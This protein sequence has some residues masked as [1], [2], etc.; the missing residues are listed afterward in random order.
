MEFEIKNGVLIDYDGTDNR[1]VIPDNVSIIGSRAFDRCTTIKELVVP[2]SV[3]TIESFAFLG[4]SNLSNIELTEGLKIIKSCAFAN[5]GLSKIKLPKSV[6]KTED[7]ALNGIKD[8]TIYEKSISGYE[9]LYSICYL[10]TDPEFYSEITVLAEDDTIERCVLIDSDGKSQTEKIFSERCKMGKATFDFSKFDKNFKSIKNSK[11]KGDVAEFRINNPY[12]LSEES[13][14]MYISYLKRTS[15]N[16]IDNNNAAFEINGKTLVKYLG[17]DSQTKVVIP[18]G[19][20]TIGKHAFKE[21]NETIE[22]IVI[23]EGVTSI[24]KEG[25]R[26]AEAFWGCIKIKRFTLPD[27]LTNIP[28]GT[29]DIHKLV[30]TS[31]GLSLIRPEIEFNE[32]KSGLYLGNANNPYVCLVKVSDTS[33]S[34]ITVHDGCKVICGDVFI[35]CTELTDIFLPESIVKIEEGNTNYSYGKKDFYLKHGLKMNMPANYFKTIVKLPPTVTY[36]LL[37]NVWKDQLTFDDLVWVYLFQSGKKIEDFCIKQ[38][39][40]ESENAVKKMLAISS[41]NQTKSVVTKIVQYTFNNKDKLDK[42]TIREVLATAKKVKIQGVELKLLEDFLGENA[43]SETD[44]L[45]Q[46]C[47]DKY[48]VSYIDEILKKATITTKKHIK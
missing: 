46:Y 20:T 33:I 2:Y 32:Y 13:K 22:E 24:E 23:P 9:D 19:I 7:G 28:Y 45:L 35:D 38:L 36:D 10:V 31:Q 39:G 25:F 47:T 5:C 27:S 16:R 34:E 11:I 44:E 30:N 21:D 12:D 42:D 26:K 15:K 48:D 17:K 3:Q 18:E 40:S 43:G 1:V 37:S 4:C 41:N 14:N 6:V 8:I 29:F